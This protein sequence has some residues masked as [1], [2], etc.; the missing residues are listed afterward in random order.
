[1]NEPFVNHVLMERV[2]QIKQN[3]S[4][5]RLILETVNITD[6]WNKAVHMT[7][8]ELIV[9]VLAA[10]Q[11]C[12]N[13]VYAALSEDREELRRKGKRRNDENTD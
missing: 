11:V 5:N 2:L 10:L 7:D 6:T 8:E 3:A 4:N 13:M 12:P 1:M 9:C